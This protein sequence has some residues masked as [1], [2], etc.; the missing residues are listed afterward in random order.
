M[1]GAPAGGGMGGPAGTTIAAYAP[2]AEKDTTSNT[3]VTIHN[4]SAM[5]QARNHP[6]PP[7]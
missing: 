4:I 1:F 6:P 3:M 7:Q 5:S 2:V